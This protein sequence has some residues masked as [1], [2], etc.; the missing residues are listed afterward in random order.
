MT[1]L[2]PLEGVSEYELNKCLQKMTH[3]YNMQYH[4]QTFVYEF[5]KSH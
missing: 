4:L 2:W 3:P 1:K 5:L